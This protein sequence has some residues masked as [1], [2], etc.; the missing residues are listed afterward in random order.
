[1][2]MKV[3]MNQIL[4]NYQNCKVDF[5]LLKEC[6]EKKTNKYTSHDIQNE[7]MIL[8]AYEIVHDLTENIR[9]S[10]YTIISDEYTDVT[11]K[12]QLTF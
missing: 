3:T 12:E 7:I 2:E 11:N 4:F 8:M 1:M 6:I 9:N 5:A 10:F